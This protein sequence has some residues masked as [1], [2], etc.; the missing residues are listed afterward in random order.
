MENLNQIF[1]G[2]HGDLTEFVD[3][4]ST[5][6]GCPVTLEDA[7]HQLLSYSI[8]DDLSDPVR[9]STIVTRRVPEKI[10]NSLWKEGYM[11]ALLKGSEPIIIPSLNDVEFGTR[12]AIAIKKNE[13]ILGFIWALQSQDTFTDEQL[14]FLK[15]AAKEGKNQLLQAQRKK[16]RHQENHQEFLWQLLTGH[17]QSEERIA[18]T[19]LELSI[20]LPTPYSIVVFSF[21]SDITQNT[22]KTISYMLS[23]TQRIKASLYTVDRKRLIILAG[24]EEQNNFSQNL[25]E[26]IKAFILQMK[27]RFDIA[28]I[29]GACGQIYETY[30]KARNSYDE[31]LYTFSLQQ[32]FPE[33]KNALINYATLGIYQYI[34]TLH[35]FHSDSSA[36]QSLKS[37]DNYDNKNH[38]QLTQTLEAYLKRDGNLYD[39][40][41]DLHVHVNT[42]HYRIKRISEIAQVDLK[43]PFIKTALLLELLLHQY[44]EALAKI[45]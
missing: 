25:T 2:I 10:I 39:A 9:I 6:L 21:P 36:S 34:K 14:S 1:K 28:P 20:T 17:F 37:I 18:Q 32:A 41:E 38:T 31:A 42:I 13:E 11:P 7:H 12:A 40:A 4:T 16:K 33:K 3:R 29:Q 24:A 5:V 30:I 8:H 15:F 19:C 43:D 26:F 35:K 23:T 22:E 44:R 27:T 45:D